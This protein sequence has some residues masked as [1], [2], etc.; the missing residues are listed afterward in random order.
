MYTAPSQPPQANVR[1]WCVRRTL[2]TEGARNA[3]VMTPLRLKI[4]SIPFTT[5]VV[6]FVVF[7]CHADRS[8]DSAVL[9]V[10]QPW[11][12]TLTTNRDAQATLFGGLPHRGE[13][14]YAGRTRGSMLQ[15]S[16]TREGADFD[17]R[18]D[19]E[20]RRLVFA[21]TRH[22]KN[23]NLY[24]KSVNGTAV[25]QLTAD[26]SS[27]I[28]PAFS[29]DNGRVAFSSN[30]AGNWD[31]WLIGIDGQQPVQ[32]TNTPMDEVHPSWSPD[33]THLVYSALART[34]GQWELWVAP[35]EESAASTFIGY[36]LSPEWSP[37]DDTIVFQRSRERGSRWYSIWTIQLVDGEPRYPTE[38]AAS[39]DYAMVSPSWS[40]DG[41]RIAYTTVATLGPI[42]PEFGATFETSD[43][44]VI[45]AEG[46]SRM[47]LTDGHTSN[48]S[49]TWSQAGRVFFTS[50]RS[51]H[52]NIW[53]S[54]PTTGVSS[55]LPVAG[56]A[57]PASVITAGASSSDGT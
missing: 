6:T 24:L 21:S 57:R 47:R 22:S 29:P 28:Q 46:G 34:A 20:G 4:R 38:I 14:G 33:G 51:G 7:G 41:Q 11:R 44:W 40:R 53:S 55:S 16:F 27:D 36:G 39:V 52:E 3:L 56:G 12:P 31:I 17:C 48:F 37:V 2:P 26:P 18:V 13:V 5:V 42:D 32:V 45:D 1:P 15:Q 54:V 50:S 19:G 43:I 30:R 49:P 35:A 10:R 25:T 8:S 9:V 23:P